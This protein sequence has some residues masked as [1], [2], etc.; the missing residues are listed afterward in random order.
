LT[1]VLLLSNIHFLSFMDGF[2]DDGDDD[3]GGGIE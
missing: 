2:D 1:F 3:G